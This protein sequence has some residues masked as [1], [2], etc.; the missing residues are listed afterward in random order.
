MKKIFFDEYNFIFKYNLYYSEVMAIP[1]KIAEKENLQDY[2]TGWEELKKEI[3]LIL[4][5]KFIKKLSLKRKILLIIYKN[6][7]R[8]GDIVQMLWY[9]FLSK[10]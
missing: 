1:F 10:K 6:N 2:L 8:L 3:K 9:R 5:D 7:I 4:K